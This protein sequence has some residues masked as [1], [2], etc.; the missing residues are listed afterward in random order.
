V[1][2]YQLKI[3]LPSVNQIVNKAKDQPTCEIIHNAPP[4]FFKTEEES[5]AKTV[6]YSYSV[7]WVSLEFQVIHL[8]FYYFY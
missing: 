2:V 7:N 1:Q 8:V 5:K 3:V 6:A 4:L